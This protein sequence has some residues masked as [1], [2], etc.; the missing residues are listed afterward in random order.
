LLFSNRSGESECHDVALDQVGGCDLISVD[1]SVDLRENANVSVCVLHRP[2]R[3][4]KITPLHIPDDGKRCILIH[5]E[6]SHTHAS[7]YGATG[8]GFNNFPSFHA[9][10][11]D[12][13]PECVKHDSV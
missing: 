4:L 12:V 3:V 8:L 9:G 10:A 7:F 11:D 13:S 5:L 6:F 1:A 2:Q